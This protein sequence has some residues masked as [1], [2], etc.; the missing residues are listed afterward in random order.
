MRPERPWACPGKILAGVPLH[1]IPVGDIVPMPSRTNM[2]A[3]GTDGVL[4]QGRD[5]HTR[6]LLFCVSAP[7]GQTPGRCATDKMR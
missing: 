2:R 3:R 7:P 6:P 5:V 1:I 4:R